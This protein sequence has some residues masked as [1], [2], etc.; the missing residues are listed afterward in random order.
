MKETKILFWFFI[1]STPHIGTAFSSSLEL[2]PEMAELQWAI[3]EPPLA[4][5]NKMNFK[6]L[7]NKKRSVSF[8]DRQDYYY[9]NQ[10]LILRSKFDP[11]KNKYATTLKMSFNLVQDLPSALQNIKDLDCEWDHYSE[12]IK[13][14]CKLNNK[15]KS[16]TTQWSPLQKKILSDLGHSLDQIQTTEIGPFQYEEWTFELN[17][18]TYGTLDLIKTNLDK[19]SE[20]SIRVPHSQAQEKIL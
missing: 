17:D 14:A 19:F 11:S 12:K 16:V 15:S 20:F 13:I 4:F 3:C 6:T 18:N 10:G 1:F 2:N 9:L 8:F 5:I 7:T